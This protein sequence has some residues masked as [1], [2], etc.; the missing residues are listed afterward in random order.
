MSDTVSIA[1]CTEMLP[2]PLLARCWAER[3]GGV[4]GCRQEGREG[5]GG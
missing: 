1:V 4:K 3:E 2:E 5:Q